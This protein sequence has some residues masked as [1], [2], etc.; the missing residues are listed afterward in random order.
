MQQSL[1]PEEHGFQARL[2]DRTE[3]L[4]DDLMYNG[5]GSHDILLVSVT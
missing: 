5:C 1:D 4:P 3:G 2:V